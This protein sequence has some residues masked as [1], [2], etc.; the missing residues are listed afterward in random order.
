MEV[1]TTAIRPTR[2]RRLA[3]VVLTLIVLIVGVVV[4]DVWTALGTKAEGTRM[5]RM[6]RSPQFTGAG[7]EN[8]MP[9]S[10]PRNPIPILFEFLLSSNE[11]REPVDPIPVVERQASDFVSIPDDLRVTWFGHSSFLVELDGVRLL[12]DPMWGERASP[13]SFFGPKRFF[14]PPIA[15]SELP[16]VDAVVLSHDHYDHLNEETIRALRDHV[17]LFIVPLGVGAHLE[18]WGVDSEKITET[19]WWESVDVGGVKLVCTPSRH[20]SGRFLNSRN[21]T[22]WAGWA[23]LGQERRVYYTGDS[24]YFHGLKEIGERLGP[25]DM[26]LVEAGAYNQDWPDVHFGP[27]QAVQAHIDVGGGVM[28]PVHW[29]T[30]NLAFHSWTEPIERILVEA[31]RRGV[32]VVTPRPGMSLELP[33]ASIDRWWPDVTWR[34]AAEYPIVASAL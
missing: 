26:T 22:L 2:R 1:A 9:M 4:A 19:D 5:E 6:M 11:N 7:F 32:A 33:P 15:L 14:D 30:F 12:V 34:S 23:F 27:E 17:P 16:S 13:S 18:Y 20:F 21:S 28:V 25:F 3:Y 29:A 10:E 24:G 8:P 31:E